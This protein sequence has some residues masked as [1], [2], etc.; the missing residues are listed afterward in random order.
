MFKPLPGRDPNEAYDV[1]PSPARLR[2][3]AGW[4]TV[5]CNGIPVMHF[6]P[7]RRDLAERYATDPD[8]RQSQIKQKAWEKNAR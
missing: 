3:P 5:T 8:Y 2:L 6:T 1:I 7:T 4:W